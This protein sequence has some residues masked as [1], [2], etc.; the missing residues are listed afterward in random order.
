MLKSPC[1]IADAVEERRALDSVEFYELM[2]ERLGGMAW[3]H[4]R[5]S[6]LLVPAFAGAGSPAM[7]ERIRRAVSEFQRSIPV[8]AASALRVLEHVP[9]TIP[10]ARAVMEGKEAGALSDGDRGKVSSYCRA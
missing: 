10:K 6:S 7:Q 5:A 8:I 3:D 1:V 9:V 4:A 2:E